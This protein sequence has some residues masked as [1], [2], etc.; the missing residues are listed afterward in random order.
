MRRRLLGAIVAVVAAALVLFAVPLA[1]V[2]RGVLV[3]RALDRLEAQVQQLASF[4]EVRA[5]TCGEV[6]LWLTVAAEDGLDVAVFDPSGRLRFAAGTQ[7]PQPAGEAVAT[8]VEGRGGRVHADGR[9]SVA[10][11]LATR[12]CGNPLVLRGS[13]DDAELVE[14]QRDALIGLTITGLGVLVV[15]A[16]AALWTGRRLAAPLEAL[17]DSARALGDG[18]FSA[19]APRSGLP[20][21]DDIADALDT[22]AERLGRA[23]ERGAAFTADASHQLR[24]PLTALQLH[25]D[26]LAGGRADEQ[27]VTAAQ[28]EAD[29]LDAT[30]EELVALTRLETSREQIDVADLVEERVGIWR[31]RARQLGRE[32]EVERAPTAP[33]RVRAAAVGQALQ[34]LLDNALEHGQGRVR[35]LVTPTLPDAG[36]RGV[37][38]CVLDQGPGFDPA[39]ALPATARDRG[40]VP[41]RGGRGL[42]L[43]RSLI[44]GEGGRLTVTS[45][46]TGTR[47][48]LVL[49]GS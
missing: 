26:A 15:A 39:D 14:A 48:C 44:E 20:E 40:A 33:L 42:P 7:Q 13:V 27:T 23:V 4:V 10:S 8:A 22:S 45:S 18:D 36:G 12:V 19:R 38:I 16:G 37:Q 3:D 17:A 30:I 2:V 29:R 47:A 1:V 21:A 32:L 31:R 41:V 9:L 24:T 35:V 49:P 11:L 28:A 25:L 5:R 46:P 6:E 43:A 34:V